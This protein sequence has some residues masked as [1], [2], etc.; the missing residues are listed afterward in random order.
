MCVIAVIG[1]DGLYFSTGPV[2]LLYRNRQ[3]LLRLNLLTL[4][5]PAKRVHS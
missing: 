1:H 3:Q 2:A 5:S 4:E